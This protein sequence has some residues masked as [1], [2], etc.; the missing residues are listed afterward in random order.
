MQTLHLFG[1]MN[2][3]DSDRDI[4]SQEVRSAVNLVSQKQ[5][6]GLRR[7]KIRGNTLITNIALNK[8]LDSLSLNLTSEE[9]VVFFSN[10]KPVG[11][12]EN[13]ANKKV[14]VFYNSENS[15]NEGLILIEIDG[16]DSHLLLTPNELPN[17]VL[18]FSGYVNDL[19][20]VD[21]YLHFN[22]S[23]YGQ[24]FININ[25]AKDGYYLGVGIEELLLQK[26][27]PVYN[28]TIIPSYGITS[29]EFPNAD[30]KFLEN[31]VVKFCY[32]YVFKDDTVSVFSPLSTPNVG[33]LAP[34]DSFKTFGQ[35]LNQTPLFYTISIPEDEAILESV[36][37]I[38]FAVVENSN[39]S[40]YETLTKE[41]YEAAT[42]SFYLGSEGLQGVSDEEALRIEETNPQEPISAIAFDDRI[43]QA[44]GFSGRDN[45]DFK[46]ITL[47][48]SYSPITNEP[49]RRVPY[50]RYGGRYNYGVQFFDEFGKRSLSQNVSSIEIDSSE[51]VT[52]TGVD[53]AR[54]SIKTAGTP[55]SWATHFQLLGSRV[56]NYV[57]YIF[58]EAYL[59]YNFG[60]SIPEGYDP[61]SNFFTIGDHIYRNTATADQDEYNYL[62]VVLPDNLPFEVDT[63]YKLKF[64]YYE[65]GTLPVN[66]SLPN[67]LKVIREVLDVVNGFAVVEPLS[68]APGSPRINVEVY[69]EDDEFENVVYEN[70]NVYPIEDWGDSFELVG[71]TYYVETSQLN[72]VQ[73]NMP[74]LNAEGSF[75]AYSSFLIGS[76]NRFI[77][78]PTIKTLSQSPM[79]IKRG[80]TEAD[81]ST[82]SVTFLSDA[83]ISVYN[84][85]Q[86]LN[87]FS[88]APVIKKRL[89]DAVVVTR[90][91]LTIDFTKQIDG[92]GRINI[93]D[94]NSVR[95]N[96]SS[97]IYYSDPKVQGSRINGLSKFN[98]NNN[99]VLPSERGEITKLVSTGNGNVVLALH[100][101]N[102]T[103]LYVGEGFIRQGDDSILAK[104]EGVIGDDR[105]LVGN[106]GTINPESVQAYKGNVFYWDNFSAELVRYN[107]NGLTPLGKVYKMKSFFDKWGQLL[108]GSDLPVLSGFD[109]FYEMYILKFPTIEGVKE[110]ETIG[111]RNQDRNEGFVTFLDYSCDFFAKSGEQLISLKDID[112]Y[113][114]EEEASTLF[115]DNISTSVSLTHFDQP[116]TK[117]YESIAI[118][119][120]KAVDVVIENERGQLTDLLEKDF[121]LYEDTYYADILRD[122]KT[123]LDQIPEGGFALR[124][125]RHVKSQTATIEI[126]GANDYHDLVVNYTPVLGQYVDR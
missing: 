42:V 7:T 66:G 60:D 17:S 39:Y 18:G 118:N 50:H 46:D 111:F 28:P 70:G 71:D 44:G 62:H 126:T 1:N 89:V 54:L 5:G 90:N 19:S 47:T 21:G 116:L 82:G 2:Q 114:H 15:G 25:E 105:L 113:V 96:L 26:K 16:L 13:V 45:S 107:N 33:S 8:Y 76:D 106:Y 64:T 91:L 97:S 57:S 80:L 27:A 88:K 20:V 10:I 87:P 95:L 68:I 74:A 29:V 58:C 85:L 56:Q 51:R 24:F 59:L 102:T 38:E 53:R 115:G 123:P 103:S 69:W 11:S 22:I 121:R 117:I 73:W 72:S 49:I 37:N 41:E 77:A 119:S 52:E 100:P 99:Y 110:S 4:S 112:L 109:P 9:T 79:L 6:K 61:G 67:P 83:F 75:D 65:P 104:T 98:F 78:F 108:S 81:V 43:L 124:D 31:R 36:R 30:R 84:F 92:D 34:R 12:F 23:N 35:Y 40:I 94:K 63:N 122:K 48:A 93:E 120:D 125:G 14:Y 32:R 101:R 55:P 3:D 86:G